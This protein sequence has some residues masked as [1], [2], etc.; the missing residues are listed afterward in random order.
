MGV[1]VQYFLDAFGYLLY[2]FLMSLFLFPD[3]DFILVIFILQL[4]FEKD[5]LFLLGGDDFGKD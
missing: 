3:S 4:L 1:G 5:D 2:F